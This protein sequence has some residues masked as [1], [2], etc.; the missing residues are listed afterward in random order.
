MSMA[1]ETLDRPTQTE[2]EIAEEKRKKHAEALTRQNELIEQARS[3]HVK[4]DN[5]IQER[6]EAIEPP[7]HIDQNGVVFDE[8]PEPQPVREWIGSTL[9]V[10]AG[11]IQQD[12]I[13]KL[14]AAQDAYTDWRENTVQVT[15]NDNQ[16]AVYVI[17]QMPNL[18]P[19]D[20]PS[21]SYEYRRSD[22]EVTVGAYRAIRPTEAH[23]R[24]N[25]DRTLEGS[26]AIEMLDLKEREEYQLRLNGY[27]HPLRIKP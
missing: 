23:L 17:P 24:V 25:V 20:W 13:Q 21:I 3:P 22:T 9:Y 10:D 14:G 19:E 8:I 11:A 1:I 6:R 4:R 18:I 27:L 5:K 16:E 7:P 15:F 2:E 26:F 12:T